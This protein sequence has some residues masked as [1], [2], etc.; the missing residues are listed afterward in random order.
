[1]EK[2]R[3]ILINNKLW[4]FA[5]Y[6]WNSPNNTDVGNAWLV[7]V[8]TM[9]EGVKKRKWKKNFAWWKANSNFSL[10]YSVLNLRC[11]S[12]STLVQNQTTGHFT[13]GFEQKKKKPGLKFNLGLVLINLGTS[14]PRPTIWWHTSVCCLELFQLINMPKNIVQWAL[15]KLSLEGM[16]KLIMVFLCSNKGKLSTA[17]TE[18]S[19]SSKSIYYDSNLLRMASWFVSR[20]QDVIRL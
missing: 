17:K 14:E 9:V 2:S 15:V 7:T 12:R 5:F 1:M 3:K 8:M 4:Y 11:R 10:S 19:L 16:I 6:Y 20:K 18:I 13:S